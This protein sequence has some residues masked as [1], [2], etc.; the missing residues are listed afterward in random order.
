MDV[1]IAS[2]HM[3]CVT[4]GESLPRVIADIVPSRNFLPNHQAEFIAGIQKS[5]CLRIVGTADHIAVEI[6]AKDLCI[7]AHD[8]VWHCKAHEGVKLVPVQPEY[9]RL[10]AIQEKSICFETRIAEADPHSI[11]VQCSPAIEKRYPDHVKL[12]GLRTP[13]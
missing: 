13:K 1:T 9:S 11:F 4:N 10:P 6:M 12:R 7:L 8:V 2:D 3:L 5:L